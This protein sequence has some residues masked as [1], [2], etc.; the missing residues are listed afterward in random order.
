VR[1]DTEGGGLREQTKAK[2]SAESEGFPVIDDAFPI[3]VLAFQRDGARHLYF[4]CILQARR[5]PSRQ[6]RRRSLQIPCSLQ[7]HAGLS[8]TVQSFQALFR[9]EN[10]CGMRWSDSHQSFVTRMSFP[11]CTPAV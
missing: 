11:N 5:F 1:T 10:S 2:P 8:R 6:A 4:S 9:H 3:F 7:T